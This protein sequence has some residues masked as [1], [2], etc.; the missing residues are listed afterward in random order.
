MKS[1][2]YF[3]VLSAVAKLSALVPDLLVLPVVL[4][5]V[6]PRVRPYRARRP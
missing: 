5:T 4:V 2:I 6:K 3:G 1:I